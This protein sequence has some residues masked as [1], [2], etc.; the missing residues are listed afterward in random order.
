MSARVIRARLSLSIL[1][2]GAI[3]LKMNAETPEVSVV[4]TPVRGRVFC[5]VNGF[6]ASCAKHSGGASTS[7]STRSDLFM[8]SP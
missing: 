3:T 5:D 2:T 8:I 6:G 7:A 1:W 4:N